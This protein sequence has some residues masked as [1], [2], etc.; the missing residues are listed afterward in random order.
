LPMHPQP[1]SPS[2]LLEQ[3]AAPYQT[4]AMQQEVLLLT[5]ANK[6]LPEI[7]V[8][9]GRMMQ[10]F[11]NLISNAMRYTSPGGQIMLSGY[12]EDGHVTLAV[13]DSGS[14][15]PAEDLPYIFDRFHRVDPSRHTE[16][17]EAGLGLA[18]V[19][20]LVEAHHGCVRAE[21]K[22][23]EGTSIQMDFPINRSKQ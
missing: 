18:I 14:G 2:D 6:N 10:V 16:E 3:A 23:G 17:G 9:V 13:T 1:I 11:G 20:A 19:K 8:D 22:M 15:I 12:T 5:T 4:K 21:S 7:H